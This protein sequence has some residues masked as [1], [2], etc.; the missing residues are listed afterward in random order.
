MRCCLSAPLAALQTLPDPCQVLRSGALLTP[1]LLRTAA[2]ALRG[3]AGRGRHRH[4]DGLAA[5]HLELVTLAEDRAVI[6]WYTGV[7]GSDDGL[8]HML[9]AV[10]EGEV[11]YG[12]HPGRLNRVAAEAGPVA[13]HYVELTDLEPGQ[14][15]YYQARSRGVAATP[16]PLHLVRGNAI[17]T[18]RHASARRRPVLVHHTA[19]AAGA[20][21][22]VDRALR[23]PAPWRRRPRIW[24]PAFPCCGGC[25]RSRDWRRIRRS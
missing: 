14:T 1:A 10:T 13:H 11:V 19:A 25:D 17:G 5:I 15:Y 7:P 9:P 23:R 22:A 6:T 16:T 24:R 3:S 12:T 18:N 8:G 21:C 2:D 4:R 20:A